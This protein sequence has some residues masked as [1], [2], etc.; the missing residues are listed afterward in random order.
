M[1]ELTG[2]LLDRIVAQSDEQAAGRSIRELERERDD[3]L[4]AI[5]QALR[6][7][8]GRRRRDARRVGAGVLLGGAA[9][10][11]AHGAAARACPTWV[12]Y[13][14]HVHESR[15]LQVFSD[16][17]DVLL[18]HAWARPGCGGSYFTV[19]THL[20]HLRPLH[21]GDLYR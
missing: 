7:A 19:E 21:A 16:A 10:A 8:R 14:G 11:D 6:G 1:P 15:Y 18:G 12:D 9:H 5:L 17:T 3:A 2:D 13:N 20:A 4:V